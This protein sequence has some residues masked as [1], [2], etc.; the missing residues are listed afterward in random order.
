LEEIADRPMAALARI[1]V[2]MWMLFAPDVFPVRHLL[3]GVYPSL[4]AWLIAS[5]VAVVIVAHLATLALGVAGLWAARFRDGT[6][7]RPLLILLMA[8]TAAPPAL[9]V[10][11]TRLHLPIELL[12]LPAVGALLAAWPK[13][14]RRLTGVALGLAVSCLSAAALPRAAELYWRPT[15]ERAAPWLGTVI[16]DDQLVVHADGALDAGHRFD[17]ELPVVAARDHHRQPGADWPLG[18]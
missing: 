5:L 10:A 14:P 8:G 3:H 7:A 1:P 4:P 17:Q 18:G 13:G 6:A 9:T 12:L 2:R 11:A 15:A 16:D